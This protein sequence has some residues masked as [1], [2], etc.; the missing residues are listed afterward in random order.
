MGLTTAVTVEKSGGAD[1]SKDV[2]VTS[3][4]LELLKKGLKASTER[5]KQLAEAWQDKVA[6]AST[7]LRCK[8]CG[9]KYKSKLAIGSHFR[10]KNT[11]CKAEDGYEEIPDIEATASD[12]MTV[13]EAEKASLLARAKEG[14]VKA[15][16]AL[17]GTKKNNE[18]KPDANLLMKLPIGNMQLKLRSTETSELQ[19][20]IQ[21][22]F[23]MNNATKRVLAIQELKRRGELQD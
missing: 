12:R 11:E 18:G 10:S 17:R 6:E 5:D 22:K 2:S 9:K 20:F 16:E 1:K 19:K 13:E 7:V 15:H 23:H 14:A 3:D 4:S 8:K 21:M